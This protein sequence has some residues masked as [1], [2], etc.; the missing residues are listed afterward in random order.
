LLGNSYSI[1]ND[2]HALVNAQ[3]AGAKAHLIVMCSTPGTTGIV[4]II[5]A[6]ALILIIQTSLGRLLRFAVK[7]N[8]ALCA[9]GVLCMD[10]NID[11]SRRFYREYMPYPY[12]TIKPNNALSKLA[13]R[14]PE[15][16]ELLDRAEALAETDAERFRIDAMRLSFDYME[17]SCV[18]H[19]KDKMT[20]E[21]QAAHEAKL[22]SIKERKLAHKYNWNL[23]TSLNENGA[24]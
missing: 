17:H 16:M 21:E 13:T 5:H 6:A 11:D 22:Q 2:L 3:H 10:E 23:S 15:L 12:Q 24:Y 1:N 18:A 7:T 8:D 14:Y 19:E 20:A 4:L 9:E